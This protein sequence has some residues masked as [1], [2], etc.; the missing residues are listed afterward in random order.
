MN[1]KNAFVKNVS[2][3]HLTKQTPYSYLILSKLYI[4][5]LFIRGSN[6]LF[7]IFSG[8]YLKGDNANLL[9]LTKKS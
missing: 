4:K 3:I 1:K 5:T 8:T 6:I 9:D 7:Q 2:F